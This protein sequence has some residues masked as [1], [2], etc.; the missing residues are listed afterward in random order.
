MNKQNCKTIE[1]DIQIS[2]ER[3]DDFIRI[4]DFNLKLY[5]KNFVIPLFENM[6]LDPVKNL[7]QIQSIL[8]SSIMALSS[9]RKHQYLIMT[10]IS[11]LFQQK[12]SFT[13]CIYKT[14][15][16][17]SVMY[18]K[19]VAPMVQARWLGNNMPNPHTNTQYLYL[20]RIIPKTSFFIHK[21]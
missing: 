8:Q 16:A 2:T 17:N 6:Y 7:T 13:P 18:M 11:Q 20:Y 14:K 10:V 12:Y 19:Y 4:T 9:I 21:F 5:K 15:S 1:D 3:I